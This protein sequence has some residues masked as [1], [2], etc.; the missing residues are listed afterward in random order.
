MGNFGH[1]HPAALDIAGASG[2]RL[3]VWDYGGEGAP[4]LLCH[5]TGTLGRIWEPV[6]A[7]LS[8]R[9][10]ILSLDCR[11]HGDSNKP[12]GARDYAWERFAEDVL[13][14]ADSLGFGGDALAVGHSGG[15]TAVALAQIT[16]PGLFRKMA[17]LD[18]II[19][20]KS[21]FTLVSSMAESARRRRTHFESRDA[22]RDRLRGKLPFSTWSPEAFEVYVI[23]G[24]ADMPDGTVQLKCPG[25]IEAHV[26]ENEDTES[27]LSR[28]GQLQAPVLF[29][30]GGASY[31]LEHVREQHRRTPGS[32]LVI[33]EGV[34]H[35]IPQEQPRMT[36][37]LLNDWLL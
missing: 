18:A 13:A 34:G 9:A 16:R 15:A 23:H 6:I 26:Y 3:R 4:L 35:F 8:T 30:V 5:C 36:A 2:I 21:F 11:G 19:A 31:M 17:L 32:R 24:F 37:D 10:R 22:V 1:L 29:A 12:L 33:L 7:G 20:P 27:T 28:M 25:A 14:V